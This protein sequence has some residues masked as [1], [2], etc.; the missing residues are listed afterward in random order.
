[1][2][3]GSLKYCVTVL[4]LFV[5]NVAA[6][7]VPQHATAQETDSTRAYATFYGDGMRHYAEG[8]NDKAIADFYRAYALKP[9]PLLLKLIIR[10]H[11]F[12]GHCSAASRQLDHFASKHPKLKAPTLQICRDP[13]FL[14]V[15][16]P[17]GVTE[18]MID[19]QI[20]LRCN[21]IIA[22]PPGAHE[23][24]A[25]EGGPIKLAVLQASQQHTLTVEPPK[26]DVD[27]KKV[28][29]LEDDERYIVIK[30]PDG[31]YQ[32]WVRTSL[33]NDPDM[34]R[35][36]RGPAGFTVHQ[37]AD[38]LYHISSDALREVKPGSSGDRGTGA[39]E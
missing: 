33:R 20:Q 6:S 2:S 26:A 36:D 29:L 23:V 28:P 15:N 27:Y 13:G 35:D 9:S 37:G 4:T 3:T 22:L 30:S 1:M 7:L 17:E 31:L 34:D 19:E 25:L 11:D 14:T 21:Q 8:R 39:K 12:M 5:C 24:R 38:G 16:C 18:V 32:L 10:T